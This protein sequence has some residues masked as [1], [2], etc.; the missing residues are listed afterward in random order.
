MSDE[1]FENFM[2]KN[3]PPEQGG[4]KVL[5]LPPRKNWATGLA[6]TGALVASLAIVMVNGQMKMDA[7]AEAEEALDASFD[8][9]FPA[10]YQDMEMDLDEM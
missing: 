5:S 10:E 6:V 4:L 8:D 2:K 9:E 3:T 1:K 7:I